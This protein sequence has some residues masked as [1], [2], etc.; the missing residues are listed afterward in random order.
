MGKVAVSLDR[1]TYSETRTVNIGDYE[2]VKA[3]LSFTTGF[4]PINNKE[5]LM[6]IDGMTHEVIHPHETYQEA[7]MRAIKSVKKLLDKRELLIRRKSADHV[8]FDTEGKARDL[9]LQVKKKKIELNESIRVDGDEIE[10]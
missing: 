4:V 8:E 5:T 1:V 7:S 3:S 2:S 10:V 9:G 6:V